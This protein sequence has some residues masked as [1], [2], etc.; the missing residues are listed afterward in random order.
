[1][2]AN[3]A[4]SRC[5]HRL[6]SKVLN[7]GW[8]GQERVVASVEL[9]DGVGLAGEVALQSRWCALVLGADE[10]GRG[11]L[12]PDAVPQQIGNVHN[13]GSSVKLVGSHL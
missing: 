11:H 5:R 12:L 8:L 4:A 3:D 10:I 7:G 6:S 2:D 9:D 1:V 13:G